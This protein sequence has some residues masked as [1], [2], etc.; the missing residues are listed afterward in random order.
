MIARGRARVFWW[1]MV[2][3]A[4]GWS[5]FGP[6]ALAAQAGGRDPGVRLDR[7]R[8]TVVAERRDERLAR[9]LLTEAQR[10]DSFPGLPRPRERVLIAIAPDSRR[11]RA[12]VGPNA[13]EWGAAFAFPDQRR[14]VMQGRAAGSDAGDPRVVLRHELAHLAL[15]EALGPLPPRWFDEGY[16][17]VAAG[18]WTRE[19]AFETS[20][21][22]VWR[23]L[24]T[25]EELE[26]GFAGGGVEAGWSY[27]MAHRV[28]SELDALGGVAGLTNVLTYWKQTGSFEKA[29]RAAYGMTGD[30]FEKHWRARTRTR[31]GALSFVANLSVAVGMFSLVLVPLFVIR[32]RRDRL[33][34]DAMRAADAQQEEAARQSALQAILDGADPA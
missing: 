28:V 6:R 26:A 1:L 34:L 12:W 11:L 29:V 18:E 13:P 22:M 33:K 17:S 24:P 9:T 19:Q 32:R 21:G 20:V 14:I 7:G 25:L 3:L 2:M 10:N 23:T 27:A 31:Y 15:H 16:A 4:A 8:F 30:A 5:G